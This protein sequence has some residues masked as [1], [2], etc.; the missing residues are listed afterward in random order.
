MGCEDLGWEKILEIMLGEAEKRRA[1]V[2]ELKFENP[3]QHLI[4]ALMSS[5]TRDE[6]TAK[7]AKKLF[8][9]IKTAEELKNLPVSEIEEEI[10]SV[11]FY[12]IKA[13]RI[14]EV[15]EI[16]SN[17]YGGEIPSE[18]DKLVKLPGIGRKTANV[19]LTAMGKPAIAVDT[20]VHR[21]S[22]RMGFVRTDKPEKTEK[23]LKQLVPEEF[24]RKLNRAFVGYGQTVCKPLKPLC[25]EC[26]FNKCCPKVGV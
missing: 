24:W 13:R 10:K 14:R 5:R 2:L 17:E 15:S 3:F 19:I 12:R 21:I 6:N 16:I 7:A 20:H 25:S 22:N 9:R 8:S 18:F 11:G 1:P 4:F 26:K 23:K